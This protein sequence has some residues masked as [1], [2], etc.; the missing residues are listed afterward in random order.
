MADSA[1]CRTPAAIG[2]NVRQIL[3]AEDD[4]DVRR[5]L[6]LAFRNR[7]FA[8]CEATDGRDAVNQA[9]NQAF[10]LII[11][12]IF[13]PF[14]NGVD[15]S[16]QIRAGAANADTPI[17]FLTASSQPLPDDTIG[18]RKPFSIADLL[19]RVDTLLA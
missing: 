2:V 13:M 16:R 18:L 6:R 9:N 4:P 7:P 17:L 10:D 14:M 15:A 12:D 5:L 8:I 3:V 19:H 1:E 11:L